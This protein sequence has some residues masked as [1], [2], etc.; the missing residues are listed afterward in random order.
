MASLDN[1]TS[2]A[3]GGTLNQKVI[4]KIVDPAVMSGVKVYAGQVD[5]DNTKKATFTILCKSVISAI[6]S[7]SAGTAVAVTEMNAAGS[8]ATVT[9]TKSTDGV[10]NYLIITSETENIAYLAGST[11]DVTIAESGL[12]A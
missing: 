6:V 8:A 4:D 3:V 11:G 5:L 9:I 12:T 10:V 1:Q 7:C 2:I